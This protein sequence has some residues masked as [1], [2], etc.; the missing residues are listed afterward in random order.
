M[1]RLTRIAGPAALL[2]AAFAAVIVGL[3]VGGGAG[4]GVTGGDPL[5]LWGLPI[6]KLI[7]NLGVA[8]TLGA[9]LMALFALSA[10]EP[11]FGRALDVAA[12]GAGVWA[13]GGAITSFLTFSSIYQ[14]RL[15]FDEAYGQDLATFLTE[16]PI[17]RAWLIF[18][19]VGALLTVVCFAVRN[20]TVLAILAIPAVL[21]LIPLAEDGG[22]AAGTDSHD[23]AVSAIWLHTVCAAAWVGGLVTLVLLRAKLSPARLA[24]VL[25]RYSTV[26]LICFVVVAASGYV[27]ASIRVGDLPSLLSPYGALVIAKVAALVALGVLGALQRRIL[28]KKVAANAAPRWFWLLVASELAVMGI[29]S[30]VA[31]ALARTAK[32][33]PDVTPEQTV[34][35]PA[36]ILTGKPLPPE[37]T[38]DRWL[39][40][41]DLDLLWL[42]VVGFGILFYLAGVWR[43]HRRGDRWPI[44]RSVLW[45]TG[46]L[47][48]FW[49][50]NGP[51]NV[52]EQYLFSA[53]MLGHMLLGMAIPVLLVLSAPL[54]LAL[55]TIQ[56]RDDDSR[57]PREWIMLLVHSRYA[58]VLTHPLVAGGLFAASLWVFYYTPIFR[59]ATE[60]HVGHTWMIIHFL[61]TGYLFAQAIVGIDPVAGRAP[62]PLRLILL[63]A[64]MALH[65]FFGLS[66][67]ESHGLLLADWYGAMGRTWG[68]PPLADQQAAGG[69][70]WSVG[71][72][73]TV[74]LAVLVAILWNRSD[75][76]DAKR[77][78][79]RAD[80]DGDAELAAYN[81]MLAARSKR[82]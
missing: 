38:L 56:K 45:V 27:S 6:A 20:R 28:V 26:A 76:R 12:A 22:H 32:P 61:L 79:R 50:T 5:V 64:T 33:V 70:A 11:E 65:A 52:Y 46:M 67:V 62:Y 1:S 80:R 16:V 23:A 35:T 66:L 10:T 21:G 57:G 25:P 47:A 30:G 9:L 49:V 19:L 75:A 55:R 34:L 15:S 13:V 71:E 43:L 44:H 40:A 58:T 60:E 73:P 7:A 3:T 39:T 36:E 68:L 48:L 59:W 4:G 54:T 53:H 74:V 42:L 31:A 72:I 41:W 81:E 14:S 24:A 17:G 37:F 69:I 29:A 2:I 77:G 8:T 18:V 78:D 82:D 51:L 63:L